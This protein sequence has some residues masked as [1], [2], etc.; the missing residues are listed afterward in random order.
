MAE[1]NHRLAQSPTIRITTAAHCLAMLRSRN[2]VKDE[3]KKHGLKVSAYSARDISVWASVYLDD[4][5]A[6]LIP[7]AI[8]SARAMILSGALGKRAQRALCA[9]LSSD[10]QRTEA[11]K[12]IASTVQNSGAK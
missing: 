11:H 1:A 10:A 7:E 2:A 6:E 12:S 3:L 9:E 8:A 4:H 5:S